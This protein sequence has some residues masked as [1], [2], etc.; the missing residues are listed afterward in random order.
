MADNQDRL[1]RNHGKR[2]RAS[3]FAKLAVLNS[4]LL[5][6]TSIF[7]FGVAVVAYY[8]FYSHYLPDQI[9]TFPLHLQYG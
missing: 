6:G 3:T 2:P 9:T 8:F 1:D 7:L 5:F 4:F